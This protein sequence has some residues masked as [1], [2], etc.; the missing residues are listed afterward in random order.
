MT[1]FKPD[2]YY[3]TSDP[4]LALIATPGTLA[5]W[6]CHG[7]GPRYTRFGNRILYLGVD[8]NAWLDEHIVEPD[9]S[10]RTKKTISM[11]VGDSVLLHRQST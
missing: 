10:N 2:Q 9:A 4:A 5:V 1:R 8:L 11:I 6:R 7:K 3:R